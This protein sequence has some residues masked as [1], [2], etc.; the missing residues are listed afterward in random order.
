MAHVVCTVL[1]EHKGFWLVHTEYRSV[2]GRTKLWHGET[3]RVKCAQNNSTRYK[4]C[5]Q[6]VIE[7]EPKLRAVDIG[8]RHKIS[9][10]KLLAR[11]RSDT[12]W[13]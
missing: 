13:F 6:H 4:K 8:A 5:L 12:P 10:S 3:C 11:Q 7:K 9:A 2:V 1:A